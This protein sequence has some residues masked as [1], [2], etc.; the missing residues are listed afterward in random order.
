MEAIIRQLLHDRTNPPILGL[1]NVI[2]DNS[3]PFR[4]CCDATLEREY[5]DGFVRRIVFLYRATLDNDRS[6]TPA[7]L[8]FLQHRLD[9][10]M[11][12]RFPMVH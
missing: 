4:L 5:P 12:P 7:D 8:D 10:Q 2:A 6:W 11:S 9:H 3:H 1:W